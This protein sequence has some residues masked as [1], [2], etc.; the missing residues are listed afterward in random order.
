MRI[1]GRGDST[2][3]FTRILLNFNCEYFP[4]L[5]LTIRILDVI[6][7]IIKQ[8][9]IFITRVFYLG[10]IYEQDNK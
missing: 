1:G 10:G 4:L 9:I 7:I 5:V 2:S 3:N 8:C 6:I